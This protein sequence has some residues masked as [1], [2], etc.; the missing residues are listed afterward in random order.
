MF[1]RVR[2]FFNIKNSANISEST[3]EKVMF[4][5]WYGE[6]NNGTVTVNE[7]TAMQLG[8]IS[9]CVGVIANDI[10]LLPLEIRKYRDITK[11]SMGSDAA[12]EHPLYKVFKLKSNRDMMAYNY[13]E[14]IMSDLLLSGNHYSLKVINN[15]GQ[16][17]G[18]W[19]LEWEMIT[20]KIDD[21]NKI[22]YEYYDQK[23]KQKI[24]YRQDQIF[25]VS[26]YGNGF[27][28]KSPIAI[29][30][31]SIG[32]ALSADKFAKNFY[33][34]GVNAGVA[35][36]LPGKIQDSKSLRKELNEKYGGLKNAHKP[37][38]LEDDMTV[39][40]LS[41]PLKDTLFLDCRKFQTLEIASWYRVPPKMLGNHEHSTYSNNEQQA[42]DYVQQAILPWGE[43]LENFVNAQ[44]LTPKNI[45]DGYFARFDYSVLLKADS[46]TRSEVT[47]TWRQNGIVSAN[48]IRAMENMNPAEQDGMDDY[49]INSA[50]I[51]I[52]TEGGEDIEKKPVLEDNK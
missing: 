11:P 49:H 45:K 10:G 38:I 19:P 9:T 52:G 12:L 24:K 50:M 20:P 32:L 7:H 26:G 22:F 8:A 18:L 35:I 48:E 27:V 34:Q 1:E 37:M 3:F 16:V 2:D 28:G 47:Q 51:K 30:R 6:N 13:K 39:Q 17:T 33:D 25:H 46:K 44:L 23:S 4:Q 42:L 36:T 15:F 5:Y 41:I 43:R 29:K 40:R 21:N 14:R 31:E